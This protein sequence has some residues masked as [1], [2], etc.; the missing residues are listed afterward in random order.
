MVTTTRAFR[1][2]RVAVVDL[3]LCVAMSKQRSSRARASRAVRGALLA[4]VSAIGLLVLA[5]F[6][7][8]RQTFGAERAALSWS[9]FFLSIAVLAALITL[10]VRALLLGV[11][12][13]RAALGLPVLACL[14]LVVFAT[15]YL[16][17]AR[18]PGQFQGL[19]TRIDA[20][21]FTI[22]TMATVGY[23]DIVPLSQ[24]ARLVV[25]IQIVYTFVFLGAAATAF[26]THLRG[27]VGS[28]THQHKP[29]DGEP[30]G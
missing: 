26:S 21:Y 18:Q 17:L 28:R 3:L 27:R 20:L 19:H 9:C 22:V 8:P 6:L 4:A 25:I 24:T 10:Q 13:S 12:G 29:S 2:E 5:F 16:A 23:G 30:A 1:H 15:A 7:L 11:A 14:A